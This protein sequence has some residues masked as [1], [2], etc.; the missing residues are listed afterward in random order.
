MNVTVDQ[1]GRIVIPKSVRMALHLVPGSEL[2]VSVD[3]GD[4]RL[5]VE[6]KSGG[7]RRSKDGVLVLRA[8][9]VPGIKDPVEYSRD[10]RTRQILGSDE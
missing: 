10:M 9:P 1:F 8:K 7:V 2:Q 4:I 3:E 6:R 5:S